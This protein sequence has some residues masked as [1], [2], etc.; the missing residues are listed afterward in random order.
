MQ[1]EISAIGL[2]LSEQIAAS[3]RNQ[4]QMLQTL[5][6]S[7]LAQLSNNA[8]EMSQMRQGLSNEVLSMQTIRKGVIESELVIREEV[9]SMKTALS[10]ALSM[11]AQSIGSYGRSM[12]HGAEPA[13][14]Q[15]QQSLSPSAKGGSPSLPALTGSRVGSAIG[16][17]RRY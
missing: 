5:Q 6:T 4:M 2:R 17:T 10:S 14:P 12:S 3:E 7:I 13:P 8:L 9:S 15:G 1:A 16:T 11:M